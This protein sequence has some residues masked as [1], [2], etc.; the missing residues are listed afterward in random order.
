MASC[1]DAGIDSSDSAV[2]EPAGGAARTRS[3]STPVSFELCAAAVAVSER[4]KRQT[5]SDRMMSDGPNYDVG[6]VAKVWQQ[7]RKPEATTAWDQTSIQEPR[8]SQSPAPSR[9]RRPQSPV[10]CS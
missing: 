7:S 4:E 8:R 10:P 9:R 1:T 2:W 5:K 6:P 3:A